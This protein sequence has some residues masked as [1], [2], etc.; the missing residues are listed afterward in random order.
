MLITR[1]K[2]I[3]AMGKTSGCEEAPE[4]ILKSLEEIRT[5]EQGKT[6]DKRLL[7]LEEIHIDNSNLEETQKLIFENSKKIFSEQDKAI[8]IGGDH[9]ISF[10]ILQGFKETFEEPFLI[11]FDAHADCI[12]SGEKIKEPTH[13][14]WLRALIEQGFPPDNI[15][16]VGIRNIWPQEKD[17]LIK[18][19]IKIISMK[20]LYDDIQGV[21]DMIMEK[22]RKSDALYISVDIDCIDPS[23]APG[24][25]YLEPGGL[26]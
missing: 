11:V 4:K 13:E 2:G 18:N 12:T 22:S 21:C 26:S 25:G 10:P 5:N 6:I 9:S 20:E 1:V 14:E 15:V 17:F 23:Y 24:T 19:K 7:D 8:F 3:N 16:L